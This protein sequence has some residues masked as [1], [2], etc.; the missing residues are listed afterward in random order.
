MGIS[1]NSARAAFLRTEINQANIDYHQLDLPRI[2]DPEYDR[3]FRELV[4]IEE[5]NPQ[6]ATDDSPTHRVGA[7]PLSKFEKVTHSKPMIS[8]GNVFNDEEIIDFV[9]RTAKA[10]GVAADDLAWC[11]EAK[12]DGC[13][14]NIRWTD[15]VLDTAGTRGD[16]QIGE[17]ITPN[18][19]TIKSIPLRID[20]NGPV[21]HIVELRGEVYMPLASFQRLNLE[22]EE[23]GQDPYANPRNAAS[24]AL[25]QLK[26]EETKKRDLAFYCYAPGV[27][28]DVEFATQYDFLQYA[29][30]Q[31]GMPINPLTVVVKGA[32]AVVDYYHRMIE[33][34]KTL[35]YEI[36]GMVIKV[37]EIALQSR[38][39][40]KSHCPR[41]AIAAKFP[42]EQTMTVVTGVTIQVGRTGAITPVAELVPVVVGGVT[43]SRSTLH[44]FSQ[45]RRLDLKKGDTVIIQRAGD[46][47]PSVVRVELALRPA[48]ASEI[49]IPT[50]CPV[51]GAA[52]VQ[53]PG[54]ATLRCSNTSGCSAQLSESIS[55][56]SSRLAMSIDGLGDKMVELLLAENL[57][58]SYADLF[59]LT[60]EQ[61]AALPRQGD[62]SAEN[63]IAAIEAS[64]QC[65][66]RRFIFSLGIR[67]VGEGGSKRLANH[68]GSIDMFLEA[69]YETLVGIADVGPITAGFIVSFLADSDNRDRVER[70]LAAGVTPQGVQQ[71]GTRWAGQIFVFTGS[72]TKFTRDEAKSMAEKEGA[73]ASGSVGKKT[74]Y[75]VA[76]PGAGSKLAE[77]EKFGIEVL[78]EDQFLAMLNG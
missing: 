43:V 38:L 75:V 49:E 44:N 62:K 15:G 77:A 41:W 50:N 36:D 5:N 60:V 19:R 29:A 30:N 27:I 40:E 3:L 17:L 2:T 54:E 64:K 22:K 10:L 71:T 6:L 4:T 46:V 51:C 35:G 1:E 66:L 74:T 33:L 73:K 12:M 23:A 67:Q 7:A 8:L 18:I 13:A 47:I 9:E 72:L 21:P 26:S 31:W 45:L 20:A 11:L 76:G 14:A 53:I 48:D 56:F 63:L 61:L 37:D 55:H 25:R 70:M 52:V 68:F 34:R 42:A 57:I 28:D 24:G 32:K 78:D 16:G 58:T 65:E 69:Q 59:D 39:G